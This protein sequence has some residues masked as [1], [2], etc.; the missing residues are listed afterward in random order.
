MQANDDYELLDSGNGAKLERF[1]EV[2]LDRPC[3]QAF[4]APRR[5][6]DAWRQATAAFDRRQGN[7]WLRRE[8]LPAAWEATLDGLRFRLSGTDF[9]HLGIFPEQRQ[10]WR[11]ITRLL[12]AKPPADR[13]LE[14]LNLFAYSGGATL[15]AARAGAAVCHLDASRGMVDWARD[16]ARLNQLAT[17][18]IRWL[19]DDVRKFLDR[20]R[21]R[22]RRYD[23]I[24]LDPP[25]FGRGTK[26]E[27][28]KLERDLPETLA[29]CRALLAERPRFVLLSSH[30]PHCTPTA[31]ANLLAASLPDLPGYRIE[32]G[33]MLLDGAA[34][35]LP[36][37]NGAWACW[38]INP[39]GLSATA[40]DHQP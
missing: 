36:V 37:P 14:A 8:A 13:R 9:G 26:G 11:L 17:A 3:A 39:S 29:H 16:N 21:R 1:A 27:V 6:A 22:E 25:S 18:P 32:A 5:P 12:A 2:I 35:V 34:D 30:T 31:L 23:A 7:C 28:Y 40:D 33:E 15:A 24:I 38:Q 4:W 20:E 10:N 19:V